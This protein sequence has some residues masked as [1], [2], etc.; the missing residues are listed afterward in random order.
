MR[1]WCSV[2]E[3]LRVHGV[4]KRNRSKPKEVR[5]ILEMVSPKNVKEVQKLTG[6]IV[7][8]NRFV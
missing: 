1:L 2:R 5:V 4:P 6:R 7:A 8:L 3:V